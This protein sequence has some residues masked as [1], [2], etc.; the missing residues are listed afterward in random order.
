MR[1][2]A[3]GFSAPVHSDEPIGEVRGAARCIVRAAGEYDRSVVLVFRTA[4]S[5]QNG[6]VTRRSLKAKHSEECWEN[7]HALHR[8]AHPHDF[9]HHR[10]LRPD[11]DGGVRRHF[12]TGLLG[13]L[14]PRDGRGVPRLLPASHRSRGQ[15]RGPLWHQT[16]L[17]ALY[18]RQG[19]GER[20]AFAR[21]HRVDP[22][23]FEE[24]ERPRH[25]R[26][27][28][29]QEHRQRSDDLPRAPR[30]RHEDR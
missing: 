25:R 9:P 18:Q 11:G 14:R 19:S 28:F 2:Q 1:Q 22:G 5:L 20:D 8:P 13:R 10:R 17:V 3:S 15:T 24:A 6:W 30:P 26:D 29:E 4:I 12:R 16:L 27:R 23:V 7:R 21:G